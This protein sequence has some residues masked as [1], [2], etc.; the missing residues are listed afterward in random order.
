MSLRLLLLPSERRGIVVPVFGDYFGD[1]VHVAA[2]EDVGCVEVGGFGGVEEELEEFGGED[3]VLFYG[4]GFGDWGERS[5]VG[6]TQRAG[7]GC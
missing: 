7:W 5:G 6:L 4:V 1:E 2:G 3:V